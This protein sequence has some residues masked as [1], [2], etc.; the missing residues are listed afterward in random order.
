MCWTSD[1]VW[2][3]RE[4][5]FVHCYPHEISEVLLILAFARLTKTICLDRV[6][7]GHRAEC[8]EEEARL[9]RAEDEKKHVIIEMMSRIPVRICIFAARENV[10]S[11]SLGIK[12]DHPLKQCDCQMIGGIYPAPARNKALRDVSG[13]KH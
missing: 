5:G 2:N 4:F 10:E 6:G 12:V 3:N 13:K 8:D 7:I 1:G 9:R 11:I